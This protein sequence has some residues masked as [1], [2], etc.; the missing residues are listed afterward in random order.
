[1]ITQEQINTEK[2]TFCYTQYK[3]DSATRMSGRTNLNL[4]KNRFDIEPPMCKLWGNSVGIPIEAITIEETKKLT[5]V[6]QGQK[7]NPITFSYD[8][9]LKIWISRIENLNDGEDL[10]L[11]EI[12]TFEIIP[13]QTRTFQELERATGSTKS[14]KTIKTHGQ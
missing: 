2:F 11:E 10:A 7:W 4:E 9:A 12:H 6:L 14:R 3:K 5:L 8:E 13:V 1:M